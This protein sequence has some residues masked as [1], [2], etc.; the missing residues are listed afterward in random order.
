MKC[1]EVALLLY[2][3]LKHVQ[4]A[5]YYGDDLNQGVIEEALKAWETRNNVS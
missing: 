3:A 4:T 5:D 1:E 2:E